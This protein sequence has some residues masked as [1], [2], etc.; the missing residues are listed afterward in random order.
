MTSESELVIDLYQRHARAWAADRADRLFEGAW[1]DRFRSFTLRNADVLDLGCG[2]GKPVARYLIE[3]GNHVTGVDSS[4]E[5]IAMCRDSFPDQDWR[6]A[7]M[8]NLSLGRAFGGIIAWDSFFH[9]SHNDQRRM[10]PIFQEH[11]TPHAALMFTSGR[12]HSEV[13]GSLK[14]EPL[15]HASLDP[16]EYRVLFDKNGFDVMAHVAEDPT[17]GNRTIWLATRR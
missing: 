4:S 15:Y 7:D 1:L 13:V 11:A 8:R 5:M 9:L 6:V 16:S 17:C 3:H 12:Y 10:F 14:G 2:S